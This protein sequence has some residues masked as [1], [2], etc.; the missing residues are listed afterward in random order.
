MEQ[1]SD[2]GG[3]GLDVFEV[4]EPMER[5]QGWLKFLGILCIIGGVLYCLTI[6]GA[7]VGWIPI[8]MGVLLNKASNGIGEGFDRRRPEEIRQAFDRLRLAIKIYGILAIVGIGL[9]IL[10]L[11]VEVVFLAGML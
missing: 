11:A 4:A 7:I 9:M 8:W 6:V 10:C 3:G 2:L 5:A 1:Q